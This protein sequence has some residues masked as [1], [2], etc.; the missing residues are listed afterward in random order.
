[1]P[2]IT[3]IAIFSFLLVGSHKGV[4]RHTGVKDAVNVF[5][6]V[7]VFSLILIL[8]VIFNE[9]FIVHSLFMIPRSILLINYLLSIIVLILSRYVF[10]TMYNVI[11]LGV[12][13]T[14]NILIYGAG[15]S[16]VITHRALTNGKERKY[17]VVGFIDDDVY[18]IKKK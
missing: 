14:S 5:L 9:H 12:K 13:K 10:K 1:M 7:S 8:V 16:G 2:L 18:K 6:G 17:N 11:S 15:N 3:L 4:I